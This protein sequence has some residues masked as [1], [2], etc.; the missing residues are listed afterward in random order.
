M[1]LLRN[2]PSRSARSTYGRS[3]FTDRPSSPACLPRL[4]LRRSSGIRSSVHNANAHNF[5]GF[6]GRTRNVRRRHNGSSWNNGFC[7]GGSFKNTSN[8]APATFPVAIAACKSASFTSSPRAQFTIRTPGFIL[9][10]AAA[11]IMRSVSGVCATCSVS[12]RSAVQLIK[13]DQFHTHIARRLRT[14]IGIVSNHRHLKRFGAF[15]HFTPDTA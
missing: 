7:S 1:M 11:F 6:F 9:A 5:L 8:A 10:N 4:A 13:R 14:H 15:H 2:V 3:A 12:S